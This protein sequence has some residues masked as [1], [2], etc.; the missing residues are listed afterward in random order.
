MLLRKNIKP[1]V[2]FI[3]VALLVLGC[4]DIAVYGQSSGKEEESFF[5]AQ[6]AFDDGFHEL[7][8]SLLERFLKN[9]PGSSQYNTARLLIAQCY[10]YQ[11]KFFDSLKFLEQLLD[12]SLASNIRDAVLYWIAEV[13]VKGN[14]FI[15]AAEFYKRVIDEYPDSLYLANAYYSLGWCLY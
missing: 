13:Y 8:I 7:A 3:I 14:N 2:S 12:D 1:V 11:S 15:K 10:Y 4:F 6:K 5:V 9:Y